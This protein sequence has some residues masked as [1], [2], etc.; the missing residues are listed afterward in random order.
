MGILRRD[1]CYDYNWFD[2]GDAYDCSSPWHDWGR[3]VA[4]GVIVGIAILAAFIVAFLNAR[5]RRRLGYQPYPG[6]SWMAPQAPVQY[7][8]NPPPPPYG[9]YGGQQQGIELQSPQNVYQ[10]PSGPPPKY[11]M[12]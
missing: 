2:N 9:Y 11:A 4:L 1:V 8:A 6:T 5:R 3:W 7:T 12:P 10:P